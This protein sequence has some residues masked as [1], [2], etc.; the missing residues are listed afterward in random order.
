MGWNCNAC[1]HLLKPEK[2]M[3]NIAKFFW[4]F[5]PKS[6]HKRLPFLPEGKPKVYS[7]SHCNSKFIVMGEAQYLGSVMICIDD[8]EEKRKL[9]KNMVKIGGMVETAKS[10]EEWMN[11]FVDWIESRNEYFGGGVREEKK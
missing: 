5:A 11:D 1:G 9:G 7:C 2:N 10:A 6:E 8:G 4:S 3:T